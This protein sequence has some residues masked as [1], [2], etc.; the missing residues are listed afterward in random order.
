M[1]ESSPK[2]RGIL[3]M[4]FREPIPLET[5]TATFVLLSAL[6]V[7]LTSLLLSGDGEEL[8]P[9]A[10]FFYHRWQTNGLVMFKFVMVALVTVVIQIIARQHIEAA[11]KVSIFACILVG[12]VVVYSTGLLVSTW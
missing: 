8:N 5:E 2:R 9:I 4:L 10:D 7:L 12:A 6:D 1:D 11:R 3:R